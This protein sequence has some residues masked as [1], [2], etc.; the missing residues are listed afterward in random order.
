M[1][2]A[3]TLRDAC[4]LDYARFTDKLDLTKVQFDSRFLLL[5]SDLRIHEPDLLAHSL[6]IG[7]RYS[8]HSVTNS[9]SSASCSLANLSSLD[10]CD[11]CLAETMVKGLLNRTFTSSF[12]SPHICEDQSS[13]QCPMAALN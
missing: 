1:P 5:N 4:L 6:P 12:G 9:S 3:F 8:S 2:A 11:S 7:E 13:S 10:F